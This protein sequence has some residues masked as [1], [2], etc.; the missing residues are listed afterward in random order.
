M[1]QA[2]TIQQKLIP[3][4]LDFFDLDPAHTIT[5]IT[6]S[7][8]NRNYLVNTDQAAYIIKFAIQQTRPSLVNDVAIQAQLKTT[9]LLS[10]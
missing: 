4:V 2:N 5:P 6:T 8:A 7:L 3:T 1:P 10:N 9:P